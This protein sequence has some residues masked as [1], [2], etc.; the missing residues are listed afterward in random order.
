MTN[1]GTITHEL[2]VFRAANAP[3]LP[4]VKVAGERSIGAG[5]EEAIPESDKMGEA[6]D[7]KVGQTVTTTFD[8]TP[9]TYVMFCNIDTGSGPTI[10]NHFVHGMVATLTA[11]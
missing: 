8:L 6:G 1:T 11:V 7:V 10:V 2:V 3:A 5:D 4:R 9:G